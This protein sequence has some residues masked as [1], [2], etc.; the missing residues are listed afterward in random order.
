MSRWTPGARYGFD[1]AAALGQ[2]LVR[3]FALAEDDDGGFPILGAVAAQMRFDGQ[4]A[5]LRG[6]GQR[7]RL[8]A[9][10]R[11][12]ARGRFAGFVGRGADDR[13]RADG[14]AATSA[15]PRGVRRSGS[16]ARCGARSNG[17]S[18]TPAA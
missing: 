6:T 3:L 7:V 1:A 9:E 16:T 8:S 10:P 18:P 4:E 13:C 17:S 15:V 11:L 5:T 12:D 2:P 14:G